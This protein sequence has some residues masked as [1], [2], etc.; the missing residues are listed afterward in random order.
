[1][2]RVHGPPWLTP[3]T[4]TAIAVLFISRIRLHTWVE[5]AAKKRRAAL[6]MLLALVAIVV[7]VCLVLAERKCQVFLVNKTGKTQQDLILV[8]ATHK[9][10]LSPLQPGEAVS[11]F[12]PPEAIARLAVLGGDGNALV[13]WGSTTSDDYYLKVVEITLGDELS[14]CAINYEHAATP[15]VMRIRLKRFFSRFW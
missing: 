11:V 3:V 7:G 14:R 8:F 9:V 12:V 1:M 10:D 15:A 4:G 2:G 6:L 5:S 13:E